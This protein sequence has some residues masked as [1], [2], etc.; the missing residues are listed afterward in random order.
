MVVGAAVTAATSLGPKRW[1]IPSFG[2][3]WHDGP[4]LV[5]CEAFVVMAIHHRPVLVWYFPYP[6]NKTLSFRSRKKTVRGISDGGCFSKM[7]LLRLLLLLL[8]L[9]LMES[10][11]NWMMIR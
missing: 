9:L 5:W 2:A 11:T 10:V 1:F 3:L 4:V 6:S 7:L 8:P